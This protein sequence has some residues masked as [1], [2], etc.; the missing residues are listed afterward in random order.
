M[1]NMRLQQTGLEMLE[2]A[3]NTLWEIISDPTVTGDQM[4]GV[5]TA[6][7]ATRN[8]GHALLIAASHSNPGYEERDFP[9]DIVQLIAKVDRLLAVASAYTQV[10]AK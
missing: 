10:H 6:L 3:K 8:G 7:Q 1:P 2:Q 5:V 4:A 9:N